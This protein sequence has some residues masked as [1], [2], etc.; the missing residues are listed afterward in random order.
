MVP[1]PSIKG[2]ALPGSAIFSSAS[3]DN[4]PPVTS[5]SS[6]PDSVS[7]SLSGPHLRFCHRVHE[8]LRGVGV[9]LK[10]KERVITEAAGTSEAE[11]VFSDQRGHV[12]LVQQACISC[13]ILQ[14]PENVF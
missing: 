14:V 8:H 1:L 6:T 12:I 13:R 9:T 10:L 3:S 4:L 2:H 7:E 5:G 11:A